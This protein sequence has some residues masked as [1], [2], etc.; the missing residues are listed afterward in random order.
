MLEF[1][2]DNLIILCEWRNI[3]SN[4]LQLYSQKKNATVKYVIFLENIVKNRSFDVAV[5]M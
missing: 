1:D 4:L 5:L 2:D 3:L